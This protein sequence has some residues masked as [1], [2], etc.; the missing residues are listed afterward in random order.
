[1]LLRAS[2]GIYLA[3]DCD[4]GPEI[5]SPSPSPCTA[6]T[7]RSQTASLDCA[8]DA[9]ADVRC[10][11][12]HDHERVADLYRVRALRR[13]G[14]SVLRACLRRAVLPSLEPAGLKAL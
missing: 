13:A 11:R 1:M 3:H 9:L 14:R 7:G 4:S 8:P 2:D 6:Q 10:A 5:A 12:R